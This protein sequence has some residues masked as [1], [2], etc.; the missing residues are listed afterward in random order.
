MV[1]LRRFAFLLAASIG[2]TTQA[3]ADTLRARNVAAGSGLLFPLR[4]DATTPVETQHVVLT[5]R[6]EGERPVCE[7]SASY[8]IANRAPDASDVVGAF[9]GRH[10]RAVRIATNGS[11]V[12][13]QLGP[14]DVE[15]IEDQVRER[16]CGGLQSI[17]FTNA[18]GVECTG[19]HG[20][21]RLDAWT[22]GELAVRLE[23]G[24]T[25]PVV[26]TGT[27]YPGRSDGGDESWMPSRHPLLGKM[28]VEEYQLD[29]WLGTAHRE[30]EFEV[31]LPDGWDVRIQSPIRRTKIEPD[32]WPSSHEGQMHVARR[33]FVGD[34][35]PEAVNILIERSPSFFRRGGPFI[36]VG[37]ALGT[38]AGL[39]TRIGYELALGTK[40][41]ARATL[42][43]LSVDTNWN[44]LA[45]VAPGLSLAVPLFGPSLGLGLGLPVVVA[46]ERRAGVRGILGVHVWGL[47]FVAS[48]DWLPG[49]SN[50]SRA[51][52]QWTLLGQ[53]SF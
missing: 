45:I 21:A 5:C 41:L 28:A 19:D 47:G 30:T 52:S 44:D 25:R 37:G 15:A 46:P 31:H 17:S 34:A 29:F 13:A 7:F 8:R 51:Q 38:A 10:A 53:L 18:P 23:P 43:S 49:T 6:E 40:R 20:P 11:S 35:L 2:A 36:G 9:Y 3:R 26:V 33:R 12:A 16:F 39:R 48:Y 4:S 50:A 42:V 22:H 1:L 32:V 27:L 24:E 14:T